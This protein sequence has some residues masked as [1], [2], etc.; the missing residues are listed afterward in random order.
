MTKGRDTSSA[1]MLFLDTTMQKAAYGRMFTLLLDLPLHDQ[2]LKPKQKNP[3]NPHS[4]QI[5]FRR[6][7][8]SVKVLALDFSRWD[9]LGGDMK[10]EGMDK[11]GHLGRMGQAGPG[12]S[13]P[14]CLKHGN[15]FLKNM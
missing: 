10:S 14:S 11:T 2:S 4:P 3:T 13:L 1:G 9:V 7:R 8:Q 5:A 12:L 6:N 15:A